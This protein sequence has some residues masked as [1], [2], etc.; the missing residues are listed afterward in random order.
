MTADELSIRPVRPADRGRV[1]EI[2]SD[3]WGGGDYLPGVFDRWVADAGASFQ[4]GE[5]EGVVVALQRLRPYAPGLLYYE[6]LRVASSHRRRGL[7]RAM[8]TSAIAEAREQGFREM[9]LAT[10]N[11]DAARLFESA[12]FERLLEAGWW[13]ADRREGGEAATIPGEAEAVRAFRRLLEHPSTASYRGLIAD[14][15][16]P[17]DL[18]EDAIRELAG[19]GRIRLGEGGRALLLM[20]RQ[21]WGAWKNAGAVLGQGAALRDLLLAL[22]FEADIDGDRGAF[23]ALPP[24]HPA[25]EDVQEVGYD[26]PDADERIWFYGLRL[27]P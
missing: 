25:L 12:G 19:E 26:Q 1:E 24:S 17:L 6:G 21:Q 11:P 3:I 23:L 2:C 8:L 4:A 5:L 16:G 10:E 27:Q 9:R 22:R 18:G 7:A 15:G 13:R 14:P 20:R